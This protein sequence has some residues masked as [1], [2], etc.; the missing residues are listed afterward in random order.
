MSSNG[1]N[2]HRK[3]DLQDREHKL[4]FMAKIA[5][6]ILAENDLFR[7]NVC[8]HT[9]VKNA[10]CFFGCQKRCDGNINHSFFGPQCISFNSPGTKHRAI[11]AD[12]DNQ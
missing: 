5:K 2:T 11:Q 9:K 1:R 12:L 10:T 8:S 7:H 3:T 4:V 6:T